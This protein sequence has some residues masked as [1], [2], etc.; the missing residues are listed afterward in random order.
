MT[1][2]RSS[3]RAGFSLPELI[4]VMIVVGILSATAVSRFADTKA[5]DAYAYKSQALGYVRYAQSLAIA[6]HRPVYVTCSGNRV[7]AFL[8]A[9]LSSSIPTQAGIEAILT[10]PSSVTVSCNGSQPTFYFDAL[11]Q[12]F[13]S[14]DAVG[15]LTSSYSQIAFTFTASTVS[16][17]VT[18]EPE[19][20]YVH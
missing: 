19:T 10:P 6:Q 16:A 13:S 12:P 15:S 17:S 1:Q 2:L 18:V 7:A 5:N 14:S 20:G 8:D 9:A 11:G 4:V 3:R